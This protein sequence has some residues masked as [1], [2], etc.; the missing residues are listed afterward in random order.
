[1]FL[2]IVYDKYK[3]IKNRTTY[4]QYNINEP[5]LKLKVRYESQIVKIIS[6]LILVLSLF[7]F[8][9]S[10]LDIVFLINAIIMY[11]TFK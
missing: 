9:H 8:I 6:G 2:K 11:N 4:Q 5:L 3:L 7:I 10:D 1:M